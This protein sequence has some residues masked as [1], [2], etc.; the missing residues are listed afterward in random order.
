MAEVALRIDGEASSASSSTIRALN[1]GGEL[2]GEASLADA[3]GAAH[4]GNPKA[5]RFGLC[6]AL[7][8]PAELSLAPG[9]ERRTALE[10]ARQLLLEGAGVEGWVLAEDRL[11][12]LAKLGA[13]PCPDLRDQGP[14]GLAVGLRRVGLPPGAVEGEHALGVEALVGGVLGDQRLEL[15]YHLPV[16]AGG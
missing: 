5:P 3:A 8:Q 12:E 7:A 4:E 13:G 10:R 1:L 14:A 11:L 2:G 15:G 16:P 9:Q 6:P